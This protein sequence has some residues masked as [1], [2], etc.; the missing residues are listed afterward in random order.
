MGYEAGVDDTDPQSKTNIKG[1]YFLQE[2]VGLFDP[3]FFGL[4]TDMAAVS[5]DSPGAIMCAWALITFV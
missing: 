5:H 2:D 3:A 4:S 1:G